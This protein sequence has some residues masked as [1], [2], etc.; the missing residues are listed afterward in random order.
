MCFSLSCDKRN[1][2][3][4]EKHE[5]VASVSRTESILNDKLKMKTLMSTKSFLISN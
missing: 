1:F 2:I 5:Q 4:D 3:R